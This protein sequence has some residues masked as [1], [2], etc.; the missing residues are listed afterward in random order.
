[1]RSVVDKVALGR[2]FLPVLL[3]SPASIIPPLFL[4][5]L[6]IADAANDAK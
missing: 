5:H 6:S 4:T 3:F 2:V 1:M